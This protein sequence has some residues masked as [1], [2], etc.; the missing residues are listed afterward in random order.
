MAI[1]VALAIVALY[2]LWYNYITKLVIRR[3][4]MA[5][6]PE[7][8][9]K[10]RIKN[11]EIKKIGNQYYLQRVSSKWNKEKKRSQKISGEYLGVLTPEG[12]IPAKKRKISVDVKYYSKEYGASWVIRSLSI[13]IYDMLKKYFPDL[14]DWIY[15]T[16]ILRTIHQQLYVI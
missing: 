10:Q 9:K 16:C 8:A 15:V 6:I 3:K 12:L 1:N 4:D 7:W 11:T 2:F 13:D 14:S 5:D